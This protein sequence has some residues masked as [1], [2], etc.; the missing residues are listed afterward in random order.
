MDADEPVVGTIL[1]DSSFGDPD[2]CGCLNAINRGDQADVVCNECDS[3]IRT[4]PSA[5]LRQTLT[6]MELTLDVSSA[7]CPQCGAVK[8]LPGFS[9]ILAFTCERC[10]GVVKFSDDPNIDPFLRMSDR[11]IAPNR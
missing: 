9:K 2:C 4:V 1:P 7:A 11:L 8:L 5:E 3:V 6:E 10:G